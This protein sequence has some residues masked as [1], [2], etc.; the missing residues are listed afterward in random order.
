MKVKLKVTYNA[1]KLVRKMP[2]ILD[3]LTGQ[4]AERARV[5]YIKNTEKGKDIFGDDFKEL[6]PTTLEM[7]KGGLGTYKSPIMHD[8]PLI[9]SRNMLQN[10]IK[11]V[12]STGEATQA[13][14]IRGYGVHHYKG[15]K[16]L[17]QRKWFGA[18]DYVFKHLIDNKKIKTFRKQI[19]KA[20]KK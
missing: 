5:F 2:E 19:S 6:E 8:K 11:R 16:N 7:R 14:E 9:A 20:F 4:M 17:P 13:L 10:Q 1:E 18:S 15:G 12:F 3:T